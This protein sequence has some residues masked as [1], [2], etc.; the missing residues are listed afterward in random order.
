MEMLISSKFPRALVQNSTSESCLTGTFQ[1]G[2]L[3]KVSSYD[4][5]A[6][7]RHGVEAMWG[8]HTKLG[9]QPPVAKIRR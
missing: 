2:T 8:L 1:R 9:S 3:K 4:Q 6:A 7:Y 5:E